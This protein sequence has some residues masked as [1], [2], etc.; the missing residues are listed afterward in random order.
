[1]NQQELPGVTIVGKIDLDKVTRSPWSKM[2][3]EEKDLVLAK[4]VEDEA[5]FNEMIWEQEKSRFMRLQE[6][7]A[8]GYTYEQAKLIVNY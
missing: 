4:E 3:R 1:M 6:L 5:E 2:S 8:Q 7:Y